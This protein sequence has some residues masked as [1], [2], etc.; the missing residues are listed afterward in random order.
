MRIFTAE[1]DE[2][3]RPW[4]GINSWMQVMCQGVDH[5]M[6]PTGWFGLP[7]GVVVPEANNGLLN[8]FQYS[9]KY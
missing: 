7:S 3:P 4:S 6:P 9:V 2:S 1:A 5:T 8:A